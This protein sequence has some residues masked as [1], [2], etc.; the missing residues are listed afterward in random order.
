MGVRQALTDEQ[1]AF[2]GGLN[3]TADDAQLEPNELRRAE[4]C[5][6]TTFGAVQK[7]AGT[8][9]TSVAA[10]TAAQVRG[11]IG[12]V[13]Q[14]GAIQQLA[15]ANTSLYTGTLAIPMAWSAQAGTLSSTAYP[16][17][18]PFRDATAECCY[19]SDGVLR[20]WDGTTLTTAI[21]GTPAKVVQIAMQ[22]RRLFG[23][24]GDDE[25]LYYS[26]LDNG[27]TL[28]NAGSGGGAA[29]IRTFGKQALSG[30]LPLGSSLLIFHKAGISRFTGWS[31]DDIA[32]QAGTR[33]VSADTGTIAPGSIVAVENVGYFLSDRGFYMVTESGVLPISAKIESVIRS[34][35]QS[36][37]SRVRATHNK[38]YQEVLFYLPDVGT[39]VYNYRLNAWTGPWTGIFTSQVTGALW[40]TSDS[41][42]RP[43]VLSGHADGRVRKVDAGTLADDLLTDNTGGVAFS[44]AA[45]L[46]RL[47]F[48]TPEFEKAYRYVF[49]QAQLFGSVS[50]GINW[51]TAYGSGS[52]LV[53]LGA[54]GAW[55]VNH[56]WDITHFWGSGGPGI[57]R[58]QIGGRG[59]WID[60]TITD[61]GTSASMPPVFS[62]LVATGVSYGARF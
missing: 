39:Y 24:N 7:R 51:N 55:D 58:V 48:E 31:Q 37:F 59:P 28:G 60:I 38:A 49:V 22:N 61:N 34:L 53:N 32:I 57:G 62:R 13:K 21:A 42:N 27:D 6:L 56:F 20:K 10:L 19:I 36:Q 52:N 8:Q 44:M 41:Q 9:R 40:Q 26:D 5:R 3:T 35:D 11:G 14:G 23:I 12:W 2:N 16:A 45:Q 17:F 1:N 29:I 43:V 54:S 33:G 18:A 4:N 46:R 25:T 15:V 30:L 47:Y 50:A